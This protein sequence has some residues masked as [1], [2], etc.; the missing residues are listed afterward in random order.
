MGKIEIF[1]PP[2]EEFSGRQDLEKT[3]EEKKN[4]P[5]KNKIKVPPPEQGQ[6]N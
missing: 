6:L 4:G 1:R 5:K 2:E 3:D